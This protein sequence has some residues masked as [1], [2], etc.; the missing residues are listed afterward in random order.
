LLRKNA[1]VF[2]EEREGG[3]RGETSSHRLERSMN[4]GVMAEQE[5]NVD[6]SQEKKKGGMKES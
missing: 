1:P 2:T 3:E 6:A 5:K 4:Q